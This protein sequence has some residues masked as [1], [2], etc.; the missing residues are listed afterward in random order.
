MAG[1]HNLRVAIHEGD[2]AIE[3]GAANIVNGSTRLHI[4]QSNLAVGANRQNAT[5][6]L[7]KANSSISALVIPKHPKGVMA[8]HVDELQVI[9]CNREK[10]LVWREL[11]IIQF[12]V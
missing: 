1:V 6:T 8:C 2:F 5:S 12:A 4:D 7:V 10:S 9:I 11:E 3:T